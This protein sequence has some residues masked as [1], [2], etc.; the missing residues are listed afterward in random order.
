M[1]NRLNISRYFL[2]ETGGLFLHLDCNAN[3]YGR[4]LLNIIFKN[5]NF[6]NEI[7]WKRYAPHSLSNKKYDT[8]SDNILLYAKNNTFVQLKPQLQSIDE[9]MIKKIFPYI[10]KETGRRYQH[11]T[12]EKSA[13]SSSKGE[14]RIIQ[15]IRVISNLGWIWSQKTLDERISKNP[16]LILWTKEGR[17]RYKIYADEYEGKP[18]GNI[19]DDIDYLSSGDTERTSFQT[20]KPEILLK[21]FI[22]SNSNKSNLVMDY[23][24]GSGTTTA[25]AHK[26]NRKY[27]GIEMGKHFHSIIL[28]RQKEVLACKGNHE[29]CGITKDVDWQ[30]GGFFKYYE[31]EQY[32]DSL[33]RLLD[34]NYRL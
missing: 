6:I 21:C 7:I 27:I 26:L 33:K 4:M 10:E 20:Q 19:W 8:I 18:L 22:E 28:S 9:D 1:E 14:E 32:E 25:V 2:K 17:P 12:L 34:E 5:D 23:F 16:Y 15:G 29:P 31:L 24:L 11:A 13:N 30:G 3:Y